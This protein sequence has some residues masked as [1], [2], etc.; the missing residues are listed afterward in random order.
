MFN[1]ST[2]ISRQLWL[3]WTGATINAPKETNLGCSEARLSLCL[4]YWSENNGSGIPLSWVC[5]KIGYIPNYS[6]LIG[7]MISKTIGFRAT[8]FSDKPSSMGRPCSSERCQESVR[9]SIRLCVRTRFSKSASTSW[10]A[11]SEKSGSQ[12]L[13]QKPKNINLKPRT[14]T[15]MKQLILL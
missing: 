6:H 2:T 9:S 12:I 14:A 7:I 10:S 5:L 1:G 4:R 15:A 11:C 8:L 3:Y 13:N